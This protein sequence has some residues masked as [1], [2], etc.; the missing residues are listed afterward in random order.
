VKTV[1]DFADV[2]QRA[3]DEGGNTHTLDDIHEAVQGHRMLLWDGV[4]SAMVTQIE[5]TPRQR[6]CHIALAGGTLRELESMLPAVTAYARV[7]QCTLLSLSGRKGWSKIP[8]IPGFAGWRVAGIT[9]I[10]PLTESD[11]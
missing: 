8:Q 9:M 5:D 4:Q 10:G 7:Q 11:A 2:L 1:Y 6:V 3:L